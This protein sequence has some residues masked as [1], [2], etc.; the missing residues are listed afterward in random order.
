MLASLTGPGQ[1]R[2][3]RKKNLPDT[4]LH[5]APIQCIKDANIEFPGENLMLT[6]TSTYALIAMSTM[7]RNES[8]L[9]MTAKE[10]AELGEIPSNYLSKIMRQLVRARLLDGTRGIGGGFRFAKPPSRIK[11]IQIVDLFEEV[12][13]PRIC[14]FGNKTCSDDDHC[15]LHDA[16]GGVRSSF[17]DVLR[18]T[19]LAYAAQDVSGT[20]RKAK[21]KS[22]KKR[23][24]AKA[25]R[26]RWR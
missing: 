9:P 7:V 15:A 25:K 18:N 24:R 14:P 22:S 10:L 16:W 1:R 3:N 20:K 11:L 23:A 19:N 13:R 26:R 21:K 17:L 8:R 12:D 4:L 6:T 2:P 5:P